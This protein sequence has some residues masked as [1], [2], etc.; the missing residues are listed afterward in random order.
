[1]LVELAVH[2]LGVIDDLS[3]VLGGGMTAL[4]G[5]T[6]AGKTLVVEAIELLVGGRADP[7][8]VRP[9]AAEARVE[10]R[11]VV[12]SQ[13][14]V[15]A[16]VVPRDGRSRAY[17]DGRMATA[18]SLAEL[19]RLLVDLHGQH[20]H[21]S[22]LAPAVQRDALDRF[23]GVDLVP[24]LEARRRLLELASALAALGGDARARARE[25]DLLRFQLDEL[26]AAGLDDPDE[27]AA[28]EAE[29]ECLAHAQEHID[30]AGR[31][32][33]ALVD[34]GGGID[35]V[36]T[37]LATIA[38]RSPF[39]ALE[40]RLRAVAAEIA[41]AAVDLRTAGE[42]IDDDPERLDQVRRRRRLLHDL[43]R[44]YG[45]DLGAVLAYRDEAGRRLAVLLAHDEQVA[46]LERERAGVEQAEQVAAASVGVARRAA[47]PALAAAVGAHLVELALPKA[48]LHVQVAGPDPGDDVTF[49][50]AA[51]PGEPL[52]PLA[53][54]ASGGE[55][56][57]AMLALRLVLSEAPPTLVFD[58]VDAGV[59][60]QA[61]LA[62]G[63]A[64]A[65][66]AEEHQVLVVTHLPQVA[67]FADEQIG[68]HK[69]EEGGRAVTRAHRLGPEER[70]VELS[71]ML[72][73][74]PDSGTGRDHAEEL[75][76]EA[77]QRRSGRVADPRTG[78]RGARR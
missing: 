24:L 30:A 15:L 6:G 43:C 67:A 34:D 53:R 40:A 5:E 78:R 65:V 76:A 66:V 41:E 70:V 2:D 28:L 45:D 42:G 68:L 23:G 31:A 22:L 4:T 14:L 57:R 11:F 10:G 17:I 52:L 38:G 19:G 36:G 49:L 16:R 33:A 35:A 60:G 44:K 62:V 51:N 12:D 37:A 63:R 26:A 73:G 25:A 9:G 18:A 20:T 71:R 39:S 8:L 13:E 47:A 48:R 55:L 59:G 21:Q 29:E 61:A 74:L 27:D 1:M 75:L 3:L 32:H 69:Q 7:V 64:L 50:L 54:V 77:R 46:G 58:E 56:A 72:S